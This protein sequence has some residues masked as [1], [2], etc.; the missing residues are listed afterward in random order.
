MATLPSPPP[1][2]IGMREARA[3]LRHYLEQARGGT[4][5][6]IVSPGKPGVRL[7]L[8]TP[9]RPGP[10][11]FGPM[12]GMITYLSDDWEDDLPPEMFD[13]YRDDA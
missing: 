8:D 13:V 11:P 1:I 10:R 9:V 12:K 7:V 5:V 2:E 6:V 4:P 3:N